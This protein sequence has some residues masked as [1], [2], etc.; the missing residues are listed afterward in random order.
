MVI[1]F[2]CDHGQYTIIGSHHPEGQVRCSSHLISYGKE[3][4]VIA[5]ETF[6]VHDN[7]YLAVKNFSFNGFFSNTNT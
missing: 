5:K 2:M 1:G 6:F 3:L 7:K 4:I